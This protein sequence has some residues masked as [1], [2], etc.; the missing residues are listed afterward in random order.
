VGIAIDDVGVGGLSL[1][2]LFDLPIDSVRIDR[3]FL[4]DL[5]ANARSREIVVALTH[6]GRDLGIHV[7]AERVE[8]RAQEAFLREHCDSLQGWQIARPMGPAGMGEWLRQHA[9]AGPPA[10][11]AATATQAGI[12]LSH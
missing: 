5:P 10:R 4:P 12:A 6:L 7:S 1:R 2:H 3:R 9:A 11:G 8:T